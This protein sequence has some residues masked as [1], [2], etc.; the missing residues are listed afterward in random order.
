V[1]MRALLPRDIVETHSAEAAVETF[2]EWF[3]PHETF[4]MLATEQHTVEGREFLSYNLLL[5]PEWAPDQ[6]HVVEQSGYCRVTNDQ[7]TR[8]DLVCTGFFPTSG[9]AA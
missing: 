3:A 5:R 1:W 4:K 6:W 7:V 9:D 8:L 2:R